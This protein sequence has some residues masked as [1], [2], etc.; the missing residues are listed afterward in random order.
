MGIGTIQLKIFNGI[1]RELKEV[2]YVS[3]LKKNLTFVSALEAKGYKVTIEDGTMEFT[4][5]VWRHNLYYLKL[6]TID[7]ANVLEVHSDTTKL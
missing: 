3:A 5:R 1:V 4:Y 2:R 7:K 6:G